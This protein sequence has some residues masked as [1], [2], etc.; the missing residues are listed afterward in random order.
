M[1]LGMYRITDDYGTRQWAWT[2]ADALDWLKY[3]GP[4]AEVHNLWGRLVARRIQGEWNG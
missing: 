2:R 1:K 4:I 3:C